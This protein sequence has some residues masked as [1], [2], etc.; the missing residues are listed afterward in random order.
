MP[1]TMVNAIVLVLPFT[2]FMEIV[3]AILL[4][5][6]IYCGGCYAGTITGILF[7]IGQPF[8]CCGRP[9][10]RNFGLARIS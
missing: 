8:G 1:I 10:W 4:M 2:Y 9:V 3:P 6:G 5:V 7:N